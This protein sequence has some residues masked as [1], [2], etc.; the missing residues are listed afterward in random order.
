MEEKTEGGKKKKRKRKRRRREAKKK[1][2]KLT[3][4][5]E[6]YGSMEF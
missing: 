6:L 3:L 4:S 1:V 5:M 2:W